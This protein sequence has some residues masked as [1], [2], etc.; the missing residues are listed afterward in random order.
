MWTSSA[1]RP[2]RGP[3]T[4]IAKDLRR[5]VSFLA[6]DDLAGRETGQPGV[7][8][9]EVYIAASFERSGLSPLPGADGYFMPFTLYRSAHDAARTRLELSIDGRRVAG[10]MGTDFRP[11]GFSDEGDVEASS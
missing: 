3:A 2:A 6:S 1:K 8:R 5:H 7:R 11:F 9:A 10:K 4:I